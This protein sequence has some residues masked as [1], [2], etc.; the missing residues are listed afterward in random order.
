MFSDRDNRFCVDDV[1]IRKPYPEVLRYGMLY[2]Y[3][4]RDARV[5]YV[6]VGFEMRVSAGN[7]IPFFAE[8]KLKTRKYLP[9]YAPLLFHLVHILWVR[10]R[11]AVVVPFF[12]FVEETYSC[13]KCYFT[14]A[15]DSIA[16]LETSCCAY[17]QPSAGCPDSFRERIEFYGWSH[18]IAVFGVDVAVAYI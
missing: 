1:L 14:R 4:I 13:G 11:N 6:A 8:I 15:E 12:V 2:I 16:R 7:N 17:F 3:T 9:F 5:F 10:I 18:Q